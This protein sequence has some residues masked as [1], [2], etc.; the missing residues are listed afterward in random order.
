MCGI[1]LLIR[2]L[3]KNKTPSKGRRFYFSEAT[4]YEIFLAV[5]E[6]SQLSVIFCADA[7]SDIFY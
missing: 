3:N 7:Q 1:I 5:I 4:A 6:L 2:N